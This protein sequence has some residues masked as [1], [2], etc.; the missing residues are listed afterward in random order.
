M[1][2]YVVIFWHVSQMIR[3]HCGMH[4]IMWWILLVIRRKL[5]RSLKVLWR[6]E[7]IKFQL[8]SI[9]AAYIIL[10]SF[11]TGVC[12]DL[13]VCVCEIVL[14]YLAHV[15]M[16]LH[17]LWCSI[18][19]QLHQSVHKG[20]FLCSELLVCCSLPFHPQIVTCDLWFHLL[21]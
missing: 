15:H 9:W 11:S 17:S 2:L 20:A 7:M 14:R 3:Q 13:C 16:H 18:L 19:L 8:V 21:V 10:C 5:K 12:N 6:M 4:W 1:L